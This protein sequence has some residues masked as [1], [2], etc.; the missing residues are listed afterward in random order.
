MAT[1]E[2]VVVELF[3]KT[4]GYDAAI[5]GAANTSNTSFS[6]IEQSASRAEATV[7]RSAGQMANGTRNFGRQVADVGAQVSGGQSPFLIA[8]QQ[9]PQLAEAISDM[10]GRAATV[11]AFFTG[12]FGASILAAGSVLGV[13]VSKALEGGES[14]ESLVDK[15]RKNEQQAQ[16]TAQAEKIFA[17]SLEG[18]EKALRENKNAL[19]E[20]NAAERT[21]GERAQQRAQ[22]QLAR[23]A[24]IQAT[25][26]ALLEQAIAEAELDRRRSSASGPRGDLAALSAVQSSDAVEQLRARLARITTDQAVAQRELNNSLRAQVVEY[27][28][29]SKTDVINKFYDRAIRKTREEADA[30]N[31]SAKAL[32]G[33]VDALNSERRAR[34]DAEKEAG[35]PTKRFNQIGRSV[36]L[37]EAK[38]IARSVG[39]T[40]TSGFRSFD[41]QAQLYAAY[42]AGRGPLAAKPGNSNHELGQAI[43]VAKQDGVTL[44]KLVD[45]FRERGVRVTEALDEGRHFHIAFAKNAA[46][47]AKDRSAAAEIKRINDLLADITPN[48]DKA[49]DSL[50]RIRAERPDSAGILG[51]EGVDF[52][53]PFGGVEEYDA[54]IRAEGKAREHELNRLQRKQQDDIY[55]LAN[56]YE[57]AFN[58]GVNGIWDNFKREGIRTI[59]LVLAQLTL[60]KSLSESLAGASSAGGGSGIGA[61]INAVGTAFGGRASGGYVPAGGIVRVNEGRG[62]GVELLRMGSNGGT[63]IPLGQAAAPARGGATT[64]VQQFTLDAR[65][66]ITTPQL[67]ES[68]NQAMDQKAREA[69]EAAYR[70]A[71]RDAPVRA[72]QQRPLKQ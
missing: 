42:K 55:S 25:T 31:T 53:D 49:L 9:L 68:V 35:R 41:K 40:V 72:A 60:G 64:I 20:A 7:V 47:T 32:R 70:G 63:V 3:A 5:R 17:G 66:G 18:V 69:G 37:D 14:I 24:T 46:D 21:A 33:K 30:N 19:D 51:R 38:D 28:A 6:K 62:P 54:A 26:R 27:S 15:L 8:A 58:G 34:L 48:V 11:A 45:A 1:A 59:A 65:Y 22:A 71:V 44:K 13:L 16:R 10:G 12:P 52:A 67:L 2:T 50:S 36:D 61:I 4:D 29:L 39:G 56:L 43:D 23:L 57:G